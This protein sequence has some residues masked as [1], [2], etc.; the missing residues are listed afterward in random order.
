MNIRIDFKMNQEQIMQ[1]QMLEQETNQLNQ[2]LQLIEQNVGEMQELELSLNEIENSKNNDI[3]AN[4]G[5]KLFIPVEIKEKKLI[6]EVGKGNFVKKSIPDTKKVI[7][8][9]LKRLISAKTDIIE[10][11]EE[12]RGRIETLMKDFEKEQ[13]KEKK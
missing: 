10:R 7:Q 8:E 9:Q 11:S 5:K 12:V 6:V 3:L 1:F 2:Q 4:L 13:S